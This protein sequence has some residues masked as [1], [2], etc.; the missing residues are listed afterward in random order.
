MKKMENSSLDPSLQEAITN[1]INDIAMSGNTTR[2]IQGNTA[3]T[4]SYLKN[5]EVSNKYIMNR[6][7]NTAINT[8]VRESMGEETRDMIIEGY[9][10]I[11][12]PTE[13]L[14]TLLNDPS[15]LDKYMDE[16]V[17]EY[18]NVMIRYKKPSN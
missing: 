6:I 15:V 12:D 13:D 7:Q 4:L 16:K 17:Q 8:A 10:A 14:E 9:N 1:R 3:L 11:N 5:N 18:E 2:Y